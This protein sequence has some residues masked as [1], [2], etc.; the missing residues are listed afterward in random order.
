MNQT[1]FVTAAWEHVRLSGELVAHLRKKHRTQE[2]AEYEAVLR[3]RL[4][5]AHA[6]MLAAHHGPAR[7]T[8]PVTRGQDAVHG[9]AQTTARVEVVWFHP[10][11]PRRSPPGARVQLAR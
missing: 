9:P 10:R 3:L 4:A 8:P 1:M 7:S 5:D 11:R 2:D 6:A